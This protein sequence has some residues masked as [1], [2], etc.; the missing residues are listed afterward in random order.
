[1]RYGRDGR[2][3]LAGFTIS[4][5]GDGLLP[6]AIVFAVL[7]LG[8]SPVDLAVVLFA[9][10]IPLVL[11]GL[12]GGVWSD[13]VTRRDL[14]VGAQLVRGASQ[15][16]LAVLLLTGRA[17]LWMIA[18]LA[19]VSGTLAAVSNPAAAGL[20]PEVVPEQAL[21]HAN[22]WLHT[23]GN[24]S[25][26]VGAPLASLLVTVADPGV[27]VAVDAASFLLAAA[28]GAALRGHTR[29]RA[30][31]G[32]SI[33]G[34]LRTGWREVRKRRWLLTEMLRSAFDFPL[35]VAP[36]MLLGPVIAL[37]R[38]GGPLS[39]AAITSAFFCGS[40]I[41]VQLAKRHAPSRPMLLCTALMYVGVLTPLLLGFT[42]WT[43]LIA[44][45]EL[46]KGVGVG[47]FGATW[48]TLLQRHV[49]DAVRS[50]VAAWDFTLTSGLT[51]FGYLI[52]AQLAGLM[53]A[54]AT[55]ALGAAWIVVSVSAAL[56]VRELREFRD[57][58]VE[59][60]VRP[61]AEAVR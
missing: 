58:P 40:L 7:G 15:A 60:P 59:P 6:M 57:R 24:L 3:L 9:G 19:G 18:V 38:L 53:G 37:E 28:C 31:A 49:P 33:L 34:D 36:I 5:V 29:R 51:P 11:F 41:G 1:V 10:E 61:L 8:G 17:E 13:R 47:F 32:A 50:R 43:V 39:W 56:S 46:V 52:A 42:S 55:L 23:A 48:A 54:T 12:L 45:V 44:A 27:V 21:R 20:V 4:S 14:L 16:T 26:L 25:Y 35:M 30:Q 22:G 2:L